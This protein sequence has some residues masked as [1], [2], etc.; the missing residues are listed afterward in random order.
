MPEAA[1]SRAV[2]RWPADPSRGL[3]LYQLQGLRYTPCTRTKC[4]CTLG[5]AIFSLRAMRVLVK[6]YVAKID[7]VDN[8]HME[9]VTLVSWLNMM[10]AVGDKDGEVQ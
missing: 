10:K 8:G 3:S 4:F 2:T 9:N 6:L 1:G 5:A 7:N